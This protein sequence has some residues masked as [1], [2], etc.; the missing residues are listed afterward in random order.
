MSHSVVQPIRHSSHV[1][2]VILNVVIGFVSECLKNRTF[3]TKLDV[4]DKIRRFYFNSHFSVKK[5]VKA[6]KRDSPGY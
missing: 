3:W 1:A 5:T 4:L 6:S 2:N